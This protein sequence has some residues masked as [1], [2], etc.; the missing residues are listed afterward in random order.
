MNL[1]IDQH[2]RERVADS[3]CEHGDEGAK[4]TFINGR[5]LEF[6][7]SAGG[8]FGRWLLWLLLIIITLGICS[9]WVHPRLTK[10]KVEQTGYAL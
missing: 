3:Q 8:L 5:R 6:F 10:W 9:F 4:H 1:I 7:G 2:Q